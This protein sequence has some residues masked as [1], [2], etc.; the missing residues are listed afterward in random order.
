MKLHLLKKL[1]LISI[2][3]NIYFLKA[4][5]SLEGKILNKEKIPIENLEISLS[6][7]KLKTFSDKKGKFYINNIPSGN[8]YLQIKRGKKEYFFPFFYGFSCNKKKLRRNYS[9]SIRKSRK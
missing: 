3:F 8:H 5:N 7:S 2:L 6:D 4:Q 9:K 1:F